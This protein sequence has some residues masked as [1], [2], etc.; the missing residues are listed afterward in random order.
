M[1]GRYLLV[2]SAFITLNTAQAGPTDT[3]CRVSGNTKSPMTAQMCPETQHLAQDGAETNGPWSS[4]TLPAAELA[5]EQATRATATTRPA[6]VELVRSAPTL[7]IKPGDQTVSR[8]DERDQ[9]VVLTRDASNVQ[10]TP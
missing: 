1:K 10:S 4:P 6:P 3:V 8:I 5:R 2:A 7:A 9:R